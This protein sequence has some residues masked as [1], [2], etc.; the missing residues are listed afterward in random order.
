MPI[1]T[2]KFS[3]KNENLPMLSFDRE[4]GLDFVD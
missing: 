2:F 4:F 3:E 1:M